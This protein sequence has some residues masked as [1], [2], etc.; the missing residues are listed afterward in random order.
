MPLFGPWPRRCV[1]FLLH[2]C[3]LANFGQCG[4]RDGYITDLHILLGGLYIG[5]D[6]DAAGFEV[7]K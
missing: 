7:Q 4:R 1:S 5:R 2:I 6:G 3:F